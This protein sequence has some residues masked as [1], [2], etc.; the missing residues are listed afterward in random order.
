MGTGA[1]ESVTIDT[2]QYT[3]VVADNADMT[4]GGLNKIGVGMLELWGVKT[5]QGGTDVIA[6]TLQVNG[7]IGGYGAE[8]HIRSG[9]V[10]EG[11][12][13][14]ADTVYN[15][16]VIAPGRSDGDRIGTLTI[17]GDYVAESGG[18]VEIN[19]ILGGDNSPTSKL[20]ITGDVTGA[21]LT[22]TSIRVV[23]LGGQGA[24][25]DKGI[26]IIEVLGDSPNAAFRL[27]PDYIDRDGLS[28]VVG[29][30]YL[31]HLKE[32]DAHDDPA[33]MKN[34]YLMNVKNVDGTPKYNPIVPVYEIYPQILTVFNRMPTLQE[35]VGN[36]SW[37]DD[38]GENAGETCN[39]RIVDGFG[40]WVRLEGATGKRSAKTA[41]NSRT[42]Y[43]L[44]YGIAHIGFDAPI[45]TSSAGSRLVAGLTA[46]IGRAEADV[47]SNN[48]CGKI[49]TDNAGGGVT[50]TW[51]DRSGF[52]A[53]A[54]ARY[55]WNESRISSKELLAGSQ[56]RDND[57]NGY[58]LSLELG[59]NVRL[60]GRWSLT[61]QA[62]LMYS[63]VDFDRFTDC[64]NVRVSLKDHDSLEGRL[65]VAANYE[66]SRVGADGQVNRTLIYGLANVYREFKGK[67]KV[68]VSGIRYDSRGGAR[69]WVGGFVGGSHNWKNDRFSV[70]GELG[71]RGGTTKMS[72]NYEFTADVGFRI[73]F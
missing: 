16:G 8:T 72:K 7:R 46:N 40:A 18:M 11:V 66:I 59:Q 65:G 51:Y 26:E 38:A 42:G 5:Y 37:I 17:D 25:T 43:D 53:D 21:P 54:Q 22:A 19:S 44:D 4:G 68:E 49:K 10:L 58:A 13:T 27:N 48:G 52:Y 39:S 64:H 35:R 14:V 69:T 23:N 33:S 15:A 32:G 3:G 30:S 67:S 73:M 12:G 62:Q 70:Y 55:N 36:R 2:Q 71:A 57:G 45:F 28:A 50:L 47:S 29:G 56:V 41:S 34:W 1:S 24:L 9:A 60:G 63:K 31:Y 20:V 6:G 61:P